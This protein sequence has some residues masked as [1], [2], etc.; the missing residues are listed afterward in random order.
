LQALG[1]LSYSLYVSHFLTLELL[2]RATRSSRFVTSSAPRMWL[3]VAGGILACL[4]V[5]ALVH[6]YFEEPVGRALRSRLDRVRLEPSPA[7]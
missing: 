4:V 7:G 2:G 1:R 5:G 6:R 3:T